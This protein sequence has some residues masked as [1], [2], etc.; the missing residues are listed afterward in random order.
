M[1]GYKYKETKPAER[2][3]P[4]GGIPKICQNDQKGKHPS[5]IFAS[6]HHFPMIQLRVP[7]ELYFKTT[8]ISLRDA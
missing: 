5:N 6:K 2:E 8:V 7:F 3:F 4:F 1:S